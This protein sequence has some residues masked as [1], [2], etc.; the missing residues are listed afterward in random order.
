M[1]YSIDLENKYEFFAFK[2]IAAP[3]VIFFIIV[4]I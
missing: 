3:L 4:A 1:Y 2:W